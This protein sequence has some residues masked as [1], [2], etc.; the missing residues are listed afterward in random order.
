MPFYQPNE[1]PKLMVAPNGA[2]KVKKDHPEVPLTIQETVEVAKNCFKAGAGAIHLHVRNEKGEHVLDAGLYKEALKELE[3]KVPKMHIQVT[4]EAV[5]KY[6]PEDMRKLAY[7]VTPPGTSIGIAEMIPSR[8][9]TDE[10]VKLYK[11]LTEAGTKIQH[12]LYDPNDIDLLVNLL[13]KAEINVEGAWCLFVIG[14]YSGKISYPDNIPMFLKKMRKNNINLDWAICAFAKEEI[15][16]LEKAISLGGKIR[17]GFENSLFM[18]NGEI[19]PNN[20]VSYTHLTLPTTP[21]V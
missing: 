16:C 11:Y 6:S 4:T 3:F 15:S 18:P 19:A 7:D 13:N 8:N 20:P 1:L 9:P 10:D 17:V 5:G 21:Y 2:R 14:H 12:L